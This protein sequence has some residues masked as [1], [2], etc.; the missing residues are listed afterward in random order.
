VASSGALP[1]TGTAVGGLVATALVLIVGGLVLLRLR[2][3]PG[4]S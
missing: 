4:S 3:R 1:A 2:R